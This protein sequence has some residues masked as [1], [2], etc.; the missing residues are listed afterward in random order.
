MGS[1]ALHRSRASTARPKDRLG[2]NATLTLAGLRAHELCN[3]TW[4][5]A[6]LINGRIQVAPSKT[7]AGI[8]EVSLGHSMCSQ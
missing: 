4:R 3:L 6:D 1:L 2:V 8:R 5:D 7:Q